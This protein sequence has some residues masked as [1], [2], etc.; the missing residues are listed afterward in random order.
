VNT[1]LL[2]GLVV[3]VWLGALP[4]LA[5]ARVDSAAAESPGTAGASGQDGAQTDPAAIQPPDLL[6]PS[7]PEPGREKAARPLL[8]LFQE[9][10][11]AVPPPKPNFDYFIDEDGDGIGDGRQLRLA[12]A[13]EKAP[14]AP[15]L[16]P[17]LQL[18]KKRREELRRKAPFRPQSKR[19]SR[20]APPGRERR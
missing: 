18:L 12:P 4:A 20:T 3:S 2:I 7:A 9:R 14:Y 17:R 15:Q 5:Q 1:L 13:L 11:E 6:R 16:D 19:P 8:N 10:S